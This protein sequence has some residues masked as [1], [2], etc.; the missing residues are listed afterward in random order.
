MKQKKISTIIV[1]IA[2]SS[3]M[4]IVLDAEQAG[5]A[6]GFDE[7][8]LSINEL[9][10]NSDTYVDV[11]IN[12]STLDAET[13]YYVMHPIYL[14]ETGYNLT[15]D[16]VMA[17]GSPVIL[18]VT[19]NESD[20]T[21]LLSS[22]IL[23][24]V[25]GIW[26]LANST[27]SDSGIVP[28]GSNFDMLGG[29]FWVNYTPEYKIEL[30]TDAIKYGQDV[31]VT[32]T[33]T[34]SSESAV[35][36]WIDVI[37]KSDGA[38]IFHRYENDGAY[39]FNTDVFDFAGNYTI[40]AYRDVDEQD[41]HGYNEGNGYYSN[42][43][44]GVE[45]IIADYYNYST[46]G[47]W[48]MPEFMA[49]N[50]MIVSETGI[51]TT[52]LT[53]DPMYWGFEG[54]INISVEDY[55]EEIIPDIAVK[56]LNGEEVDVT[57]YFAE[58]INI[59]QDGKYVHINHSSWGVNDTWY[60]GSAW[61]NGDGF[62][63]GEN[64]TWSICLSKDIDD[65]GTEEWNKTLEFDVTSAPDIQ[66]RWIDDDGLAFT[67]HDNDGEIPAI[68]PIT[69][70]PLEVKFQVI[71]NDPDT[72]LDDTESITVSGDALFTGTLEDM[73]KVDYDTGTWTV[74]LTPYMVSG[75]STIAF[76][77]EWDGYGTHT[78]VLKV[79]GTGLNGSVVEISPSIF[80]IDDDVTIEIRVSTAYADNPYP[81]MNADVGIYWLKDD[82]SLGTLINETSSSDDPS[83]N[84]YSFMFNAS[85]QNDQPDWTEVK[86]P[87][88]IVA[89]V[90][91]ANIGCGYATATMNPKSDLFVEVSTSSI[92]AGKKTSFEVNVTLD[93]NE[94]GETMY[95]DED[96]H[97]EIYD[98]SGDKVTLDDDFGSIRASDLDELTNS[99]CAYIVKPG[100]Y[101]LYAYNNTHDSAGNN[102]T[103][104]VKAVD[105]LCNIDGGNEL[106]WSVDENVSIE[107]TVGYIGIPQNGTL[108]IF[109]ISRVDDY[110][111]AWIGNK[112]HTIAVVD[113]IAAL[114]NVT[115]NFLPDDSSK[116][117]ITFAFKPK[118]GAYANANDI[119]PV[120]IPDV[121]VF[122]HTIPHNVEALLTIKT[123]GR[124]I[125]L[126][127]VKVNITVPGVSGEL[128]SITKADGTS[129]FAFKPLTT[130]DIIIKIEGK[131]SDVTA[132]VTSWSLYM[133]VALQV[134]ENE[135]FIV[136]VRNGSSTGSPIE[137]VMV[138]FHGTTETTNAEGK[139]TFMAPSVTSTIPYELLATLVGHAEDA[140]MIQIINVPKLVII[141]ESTEVTAGSEFT[142]VIADDLGAAI[143]G[144]TILFD[145]ETYTSSSNGEAKLSAPDEE[146]TSTITAS[147]ANFADADSV[148]VTID[149]KEI[150][151]FELLSLIAALGVACILLKKRKK[152]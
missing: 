65:D 140:V 95:P 126:P 56:I 112:S 6:P 125:G 46:C 41:E 40:Q 86:A 15:W 104:E 54:K 29:F 38:K 145:G 105:I 19:E 96:I 134:E 59:R 92:L 42:E 82:G 50:E 51:L 67:G 89:Y 106:I 85:E 44:G 79:G 91:V 31:E 121:S 151:G 138:L 74:P 9:T 148:V 17:G 101:T 28:N 87:R 47:P 124:G 35:G 142:V 113:G 73:P 83:N 118:Y 71:G 129:T 16:K 70:Q 116:E 141:L 39:I 34:D 10:Y 111:R 27:I 64:D 108:E 72:Y 37:R 93:I 11:E 30:S 1:S 69:E 21:K 98:E 137:G 109:N 66:F 136:I 94:T 102:A 13:D 122:P 43:Y 149:E 18:E 49:E 81:V 48:D 135:E 2:L 103:L 22:E 76:H 63:F 146:G 114:E 45:P 14:S 8:G 131:I 60:N 143:I 3:S 32:I 90:D 7:W 139:V 120:K 75:G 123:T 80:A 12:T 117:Q 25:C 36:C 52:T 68:P 100:I 57:E 110:Y 133:D 78:E 4:M 77:V 99:I 5:A 147:K 115:A 107:F 20:S 152:N 128:S 88:D 150:P 144:A 33:V 24:D 130:G 55:D 127:D 61:I 119:L 23:L 58:D 97:M 26:I 62:V 84:L 132:Q 53:N